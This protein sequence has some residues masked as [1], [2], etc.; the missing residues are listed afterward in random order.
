MLKQLTKS[1]L[2][3]EATKLIENAET[4]ATLHDIFFGCSDE[5]WAWVLTQGRQKIPALQQLLPKLPDESIQ[6][7]YTG[8]KGH[9]GLKSAVSIVSEF[10]KGAQTCG[11][12]L[13]NPE[14]RILDFGC[15][16]GRITQ[17]LLRDAKLGNLVAADV[18]QA[19]L[20]MCQ[21]AGFGCEFTQFDSW[22]PASVP[23]NSFDLIV[24]FSVFSHLSEE[25][26]MAWVEEL[27]KKLKP[28]GVLAASTRP[29]SFIRM[30]DDLRK[31]TDLPA[32]A[33]GAARAFLD[34]PMWLGKYDAGEFCFDI[35]GEGGNQLSRGVYGEAVVPEQYVKRE[36][37]RFF[38]QVE[39]VDVSEH[40][41][42]DQSVLIGRKSLQSK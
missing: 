32:H 23:D 29:R 17:V 19:A 33:G 37:G 2:E 34:T 15:G 42:F 30:V 11:L 24:G 12:D 38:D 5:L 1:A 36:W 16:W 39:Y 41:R 13:N 35:E 31:R 20:D 28:G 21:E 14:L 8:K 22:P 3:N 26:H 10:R 7:Q 40:Q 18:Q 27:S 4:N 9:D 25:N 6:L